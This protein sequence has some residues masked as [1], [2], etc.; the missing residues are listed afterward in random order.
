MIYIY[1]YIFIFLFLYIIFCKYYYNLLRYVTR[2]DVNVHHWQTEA[3]RRKRSDGIRVRSAGITASEESRG[4]SAGGLRGTG[5][6]GKKRNKFLTCE[7]KEVR[8][9]L[10]HLVKRTEEKDKI[11]LTRGN[12]SRCC[13]CCCCFWIAKVMWSTQKEGDANPTPPRNPSNPVPI[14]QER[15][16]C[17]SGS[18]LILSAASTR[19]KTN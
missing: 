4:G 16:M 7:M 14:R 5:W 12:Y 3:G 18:A 10:K 19:S 11:I 6:K 9:V 17:R 15:E 1:I 8:R 2:G 13:C